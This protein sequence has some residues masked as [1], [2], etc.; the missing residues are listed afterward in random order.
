MSVGATAVLFDA[1]PTPVAVTVILADEKPTIY[2]GVPTLYAALLAAWT[3]GGKPNAPLRTCISAGDALPAEIGRKW[4]EMWG[5]DI[6]DRVGSTEML[7]IF[8]SNARGDVEYGTSGV[9]VPGYDVRLVDE[10]DVP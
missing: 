4:Q 10:Q 2:C 5:V 7:H 6:L 3:D 1:R 9:A 8:L